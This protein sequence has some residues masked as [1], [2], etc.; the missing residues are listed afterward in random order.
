[1][2]SQAFFINH[3]LKNLLCWLKIIPCP[4]ICWLTKLEWF[5]VFCYSIKEW[6]FWDKKI[7]ILKAYSAEIL[8][9]GSNWSIWVKRSESSGVIWGNNF[10]HFCFVLFGK[11]LIYF[12]ASSFVMYLMSLEEGVPKT[13]MILWTWSRKSSPGNKAVLPKS[14]AA[15]HPT[16]QMS[17]ALLY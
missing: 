7:N 5:V 14:S 3:V 13:E 1:M 15:M 16:D 10:Y 2:V 8:F 12:M 9:S 6:M 4:I 11:D 17:I